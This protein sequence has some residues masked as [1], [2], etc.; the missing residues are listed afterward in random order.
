MG[1]GGKKEAQEIQTKAHLSSDPIKK[2]TTGKPLK[3]E[4]KMA[5]KDFWFKLTR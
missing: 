3:R 1:I 5:S 2:S 4:F